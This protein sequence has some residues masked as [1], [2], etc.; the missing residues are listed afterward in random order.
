[1]RR[2]FLFFDHKVGG[3]A[4]FP[5]NDSADGRSVGGRRGDDVQLRAFGQLNDAANFGR[6]ASQ[7]F[8]TTLFKDPVRTAQ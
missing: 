8:G 5:A 4:S 6:S 1:M 7:T 2:D 3:V